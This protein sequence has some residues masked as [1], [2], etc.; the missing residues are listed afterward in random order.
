MLGLVDARFCR[1]V[2]GKPSTRK[3]FGADGAAAHR[4]RRVADLVLHAVP[5]RVAARL[6]RRLEVGHQEHAAAGRRNRL[7]RLGVDDAAG[8]GVGGLDQRRFAG[9]RD[10]LFERADF[11]RDVEA[12]E[13]L[14]ADRTPLRSKVRKPDSDARQSCRSRDR[15]PGTSTRRR[16]W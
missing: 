8:G 2:T 6:H 12:D 9:D 7:E 5:V 14:R 3:L 10:G 1:S 15:A 13:L 16:R 4:H 11:E